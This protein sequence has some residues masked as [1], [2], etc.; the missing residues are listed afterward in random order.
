MRVIRLCMSVL[1]LVAASLVAT[2]ATAQPRIILQLVDYVG[3]DY[4]G[5][6]SAGEIINEE[7]YAEMV[8]FSARIR[9]GLA[10]LDANDEVAAQLDLLAQSLQQQI[11]AKQEPTRIAALTQQ[12][13]NVLMANFELDLTPR[14]P[15][16]LA[17]GKALYQQNCIACHGASGHGDGPAAAS[18]EPAPTDFHDV[19]RARERSLFGLYN[20]VTLGVAGTSMVGFNQLSDAERWSLAFYVGGLFA[21]E[22][23]AAAT[24]WKRNPLTVEQ[25][26]TLAPAELADLVDGEMRAQ[27][28]R[29][30]PNSLFADQSP[31][32][33]ARQGIAES[34][35]LYQ[36]GDVAAAKRAAITAYLEGFELSEASLNNVNPEL[37]R[38]I[39][40]SM[41]AYRRLLDGKTP[42]EQVAESAQGLKAQLDSADE[43]LAGDSL[44][45]SVA[46][47]SS[48]IILLR[49]GLEAILVVAAMAAFLAKTGNVA[50]MRW[51]HTGWIL[52]LIAGGGTWAVSN[53]LFAISGATR[54]LTEGFT[55]LIAAAI[56]F[57]V[58]FWMHSRAN[59]DKWNEY[60]KTQMNSAVTSGALWSFAIVSFLAVYREIF[61]VILFYQALWAQVDT[62]AH[63]AVLGGAV[64][65]AALL[66]VITVLINRFG[67]RLPLSKFFTITAYL[68]IALAFVFAGKGVAALQEAGRIPMDPVNFPRIELLGIY[69][70]LQGLVLQAL[71]LALAI[72]LLLWQKRKAA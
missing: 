27:Y 64:A 34:V 21:E 59:A 44:S 57:Y 38:E 37:M 24:A 17:T 43:A 70:N 52:A 49:E 25:A 5:A 9:D 45:P 33:V 69:P 62:T 13:R 26:V 31:L 6:I 18:L 3:V 10:A 47:S 11:A 42:V 4:P 8:E 39:E 60:I 41:M 63:N 68:M 50:G 2:T 15:P 22:D 51:L 16:E 58:G 35:S 30:N 53:W 12:L 28:V 14:L 67:M 20:T 56:L 19:E 40:V 72:G 65:G 7:E 55:A 71:V 61:E 29:H 48:L 54:E 23:A 46:F 66:A 1:V 32:D 36:A